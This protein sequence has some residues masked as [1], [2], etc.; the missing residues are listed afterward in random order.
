MSD[1]ET[2]L[3]Q[4]WNQETRPLAEEAW[5]CYNAGAIRASIAATW[6]AVAA[7]II[8]KLIQL[9]EEGDGDA[10]TFRTEVV[11]AQEKGLAPDGV[12]DMQKIE[13]DLL[14]KAVKFELIDS[15]DERELGRIRE[16]RHLCVHPSLRN[17]GDV[18]NPR[19]EIARGHLSIALDRLLTHP[20]TQGKK[21][22]DTFLSYLCAPSFVAAPSHIQAAFFDR[23]RTATR[24]N[25]VK[26][27]AKH[28]LRE[29]DAQQAITPI[30]HADRAA[31]AL[32]AFAARDRKL[33]QSAVASQH[34]NFLGADDNVQ[35]RALVRLGEQDYFWDNVDPALI[36]K[37][38]ALIN[39]PLSDPLPSQ[40]L[41]VLAMVRSI[42]VRKNLPVLEQ[43][44]E[45]LSEQQKQSI[46]A[47]HPD[48]Y[49]VPTVIAFIENARNFRSGEE[50]GKL[51]VQHSRFLD[52]E[53]IKTSLTAWA[54][55]LECREANQMPAL[56]LDFYRETAHLGSSRAAA[57]R[58]FLE[59][60]KTETDQRFY[61]YPELEQALND[62]STT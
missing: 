16:D 10:A 59:I 60:V 17:L 53:E 32:A 24:T 20:P 35:L 39:R 14:T 38:K 15:I 4:V 11:T 27:T 6:S 46:I 55:N 21:A 30:E 23:V 22:L 51:L 25:I 8:T 56:A 1:L 50:A 45:S 2:L 48:P 26:V 44:F 62:G 49:F 61:H 34:N 5:R 12:R 7:D 31:T 3:T 54:R 33:V 19:P 41:A 58:D 28:A 29:I 57:F 36:E 13:A 9:A 47:Q 42:E 18:Y 43:R 40:P 52:H 37:Y